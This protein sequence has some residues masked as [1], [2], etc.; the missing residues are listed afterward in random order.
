MEIKFKDVAFSY[1]ANTSLESKILNSI[2]INFESGKVYGLIGKSGSGKTTLIQLINGLLL[3]TDG[4]VMIGK[5][6]IDSKTKKNSLKKI[7]SNIGV[8]FQNS[9]DQFFCH[10]VQEE[11][12]FGMRNFDINVNTIEKKVKDAI[13]I[14]GLSNDYLFRNPLSLSQGEMRKVALATVLAYNP[15]V[16][17]L[18]EP[19]IGL[20]DLGKKNLI[21]L[22][23]KLK[24]RYEK[25]FI[26]VSH[27]TNFLLQIVDYVYLLENGQ[28]SNEGDKYTVLSNEEVLKRNNIM[29]PDLLSFS[30]LVFKSKNIK[31]GYRDDINDLIKDIYRHV[32]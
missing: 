7:R 27:D 17:V 15:K 5:L 18:D 31:L 8:V 2:N 32:N 26:V 14:V 4:K 6:K 3:P 12:E 10:T 19:T 13:K 9:E 29:V 1:N 11:I 16:I 25:T 28:I 21:K 20:D 22:I 23:R 30:N 24:L